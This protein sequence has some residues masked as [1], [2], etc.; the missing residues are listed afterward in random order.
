[1]AKRRTVAG[2]QRDMIAVRKDA[3][4]DGQN[5]EAD[6][7]AI[8]VATGGKLEP[9]Q[10]GVPSAKKPKKKPEDG[11]LPKDVKDKATAADKKTEKSDKFFGELSFVE[12][13]AGV[14]VLQTHETGLMKAQLDLTA[15][16]G[17]TPAA[18]TDEETGD[19][20]KA[21]GIDAAALGEMVTKAQTGD[22]AVLAGAMDS[23]IHPRRW[24]RLSDVHKALVARACPVEIHTDI[25]LRKAK[26]DHWEGGEGL[27]PGNQFAANG[28]LAESPSVKVDMA[29][30]V[31]ADAIAKD[32]DGAARVTRGPVAWMSVGVNKAQAFEPGQPGSTSSS[33]S[34]FHVRDEFTFA[35]GKCSN[36]QVEFLFDGETVQGRWLAKRASDGWTFE[37]AESQRF[38]SEAL[39]AKAG[40]MRVHCPIV[41]S[42]D[43]ERLI[44]GMVLVPETVDAQGDIISAD[45]IKQAAH[46]FLARYNRETEMGVQHKTFN[47]QAELVESYLAPV[48]FTL[49]GRLILQ[50]TWMITVHVTDDAIWEKVKEGGI[51]GFSIGG[52]AKVRRLTPG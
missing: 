22:A 26:D 21:A 24:D 38:E 50:G 8:G 35:V 20:A 46:D 36:D 6:V 16:F 14:G 18:L 33:W 39:R 51:T 30:G 49:E 37:Q 1:M 4:G 29:A 31:D 11:D 52:T 15:S 9:A 19:L 13:D 43:E 7:G 2:D 44:T 25:R 17:W 12:G 48:P 34:R 41:K 32:L 47:E 45:A 5:G 27:T 10:G 3:V 28:F 23:L 40:N 42:D